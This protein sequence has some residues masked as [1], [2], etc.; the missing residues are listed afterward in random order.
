MA[1]LSL[2][3]QFDLLS[4]ISSLKKKKTTFKERLFGAILSLLVKKWSSIIRVTPGVSRGQTGSFVFLQT[5][6]AVLLSFGVGFCC[7]VSLCFYS[8]L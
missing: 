1:S 4:L 8:V 7:F 3:F 2:Y 6:R 5:S